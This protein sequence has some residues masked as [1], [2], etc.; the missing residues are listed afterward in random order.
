MS[1]N[2]YSMGGDQFHGG[3]S[4]MDDTKGIGDYIAA[5]KR[6]KGAFLATVVT[7][8]VIALGVA[9]GLPAVY[10]SSATILIEQQDIPQEL[11][12]TTI[13]TFADQRIQIISQRV[14]TTKNLFDIIEKYNLYEDDRA[15]KTKEEVIEKMRE[16]IE[17]DMVSAEMIDPRSG[18]PTSATIAFTLAYN[19]ETPELAQKVANELVSLYLRENL[20]SRAESTAET[21][22]FLATESERLGSQIADLETRLAEFKMTNKDRLP[23]LMSLNMQMMQRT[24]QELLEIDRNIQ[25]IKERKIMLEA[26]MV[27]INPYSTM[28]SE[29]G[30]RILGSEARLKSLQALYVTTASRYSEDHPDVVKMRK[31]IEALEQEVGGVSDKSELRAQYEAKKA[32]LAETRKRYSDDHPDVKALEQQV[33]SL[34]KMLAKPASGAAKSRDK[35][36]TPDNPAYIQLQSQLEAAESELKSYQS[37]RETLK[38][39]LDRIEQNLTQTP[40][41]E[42]EY[43]TLTRDYE[44]AVAKYQEIKAK[45]LQA[46]MAEVMEKESKGERFSLIEPPLLPEVPDKPNRIAIIFLGLVLS[47]GGGLG[48]VVVGE[49]MDQSIRGMRGVAAVV[50]MAP[51]AEIPYMAN[52]G[53]VKRSRN[54]RFLLILSVLGFIVL[55]LLA[56][57]FFYKPLDVLWYMA[58]RKLGA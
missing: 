32:D 7:L 34:E 1:V 54:R 8:M 43:K 16:D 12:Q 58:M 26:Q 36:E 48:V 51:L 52:E 25:S 39:K 30:E 4:M 13:T 28:Y 56:V 40:Q 49:S 37:T 23:E 2:A 46:Q 29:T 47:L 57:H 45:Q 53:D 22:D 44:N 11:V 14:M 15:K 17:F 55:A 42:R 35:D 3:T 50:G 33:A 21:S 6:K 19:N 10:K 5:F 38:K 20:R 27:Q 31:E 18:R 41:V 24:E 9:F